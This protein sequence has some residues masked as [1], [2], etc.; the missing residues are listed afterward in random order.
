MQSGR[1]SEPLRHA[2]PAA[3]EQVFF[4]YDTADGRTVIVDSIDSVPMALRDR[5]ERVVFGVNSP[6][7]VRS[8]SDDSSEARASEAGSPLPGL[9]PGFAL[10]GASFGLGAGAGALLVALVLGLFGARFGTLRRLVLGGIV[11]GGL[12]FVAIGAYLGWLQRSAGLGDATF[13]SPRELVDEAKKVVETVERRRQEQ[14]RAIE[15][16]ERLAK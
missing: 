3:P 4:R 15:E 10:D 2:T 11:V 1:V 5:A 13:A 8:S 12:A 6:A 9:P 14:E 16:A 7:D